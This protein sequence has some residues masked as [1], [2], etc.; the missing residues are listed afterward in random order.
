MVAKWSDSEGSTELESEDGQAHLCVMANDDKYD[1]LEHDK[2]I[3]RY[4]TILTLV[5]R[6][7]S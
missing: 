2:I 3:K 5:L 7:I 6:R 4:L 1:D